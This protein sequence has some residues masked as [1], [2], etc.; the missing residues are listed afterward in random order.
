M[1]SPLHIVLIFI[2][3]TT[4]LR[5][6]FTAHSIRCASAFPP[7]PPC[8]LQDKWLLH[9]VLMLVQSWIKPL[10]YLQ[11]TMV[12]YDYASDVLLNKTKWVLEKLISLEQGVVILIKKVGHKFNISR[13]IITVSCKYFDRQHHSFSAN[14]LADNHM[15]FFLLVSN[16]NVQILN[17][18]VMTTTVSELDLFPT[19]LQPDILESVMNDYS[20]L[21]C[22]KKD[23]HKIEILLKLLKCRR[24]DMY[25]CA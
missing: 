19:D 4:F 22:F 10:V 21:S 6:I 8:V 7:C 15:P 12:R 2:Y 24:N 3:R 11:T 14:P 5:V 9:A 17:E 16:V 23:A 1:A 20:L 25:N 18:A 13:K